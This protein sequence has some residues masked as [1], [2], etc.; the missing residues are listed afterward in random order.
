MRS[1]NFEMTDLFLKSNYWILENEQT[2]GTDWS[3]S[4]DHGNFPLFSSLIFLRAMGM[5]FLFSYPNL[6]LKSLYKEWPNWRL[7]NEMRKEIYPAT[8]ALTAL[9]F[10]TDFPLSL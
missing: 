7:R 5:I 9:P 8:K 3:W 4:F 10:Y 1:D 2:H 6:R